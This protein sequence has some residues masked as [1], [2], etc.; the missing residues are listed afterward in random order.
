M[1]SILSGGSRVNNNTW[2][3]FQ[4]AYSTAL[5]GLPV[6]IVWGQARIT[7][8]CTWYGGFYYTQGS[9][10]GSG[11]GGKGGALSSGKYSNQYNYYASA[12]FSFCEG[13]IVN[14]VTLYYNSN[15]YSPWYNWYSEPDID[16]GQSTAGNITTGTPFYGNYGQDPWGYL[17]ASYPAQALSYRGNAFLAYENMSL[18]SSSSLP[19]I[20]CEILAPINSGVPALGPDANPFDVVIDFLTNANYGIPGFSSAWLGDW[21]QANLY[22]RA[23]GLM[24]SPA[25]TSQTTGTQFLQDLAMAINCEFFLSNGQLQCVPYADQSESGNGVVYS[26]NTTPI[27][28]LTTDDFL[29]NQGG[30]SSGADTP[31]TITRKNRALIPNHV[32]F[33]YLDRGQYYNPYTVDAWDEASIAQWRQRDDDKQTMHMFCLQSAAQQSA[34]LYLARKQI[35]TT[36]QFTV[37]PQFVLL[38]PMDVVTLTEPQ[39]GMYNVP[40]RITE[41]KENDDYTLTITADEYLGS[42]SAPL[43]GSQPPLAGVPNYNAPAPAPNSPVIFEPPYQ[44]AN[45]LEVWVAVSAQDAANYGGCNVW[46][47]TDNASYSLLGNISGNATMGTLTAALPAVAAALSGTTIDNTNTLAVDLTESDGGL[48]SVTATAMQSGNTACYV[49]G[50]IIAFQTATLTA[51]NKYNLAPL[52][53]GLYDSTIGA[54]AAGSNFVALGSN[55]NVAKYDYTTDKIG[56]AVYFKFQSYNIYEGGLLDLAALPVTTYTITGSPLAAA[57]AAPTNLRTVFASGFLQLWWDEITDF[58]SGILYKVF[59]GPQ[60]ASAMQVGPAQAHPPFTIMGPDTY[61]VVACVQPAVG[62]Y[63]Q[64]A[65]VSLAIGG[66]MLVTNVLQESNEQANNWPGSLENGAIVGSSPNEIIAVG[67]AVDYGLASVAVDVAT[68][69]GLASA[70][71]TETYD[72]GLASQP[73]TSNS[74]NETTSSD[75]VVELFIDA[76]N[77]AYTAIYTIAG[78]SIIDLGYVSTVDINVQWSAVGVPAGQNILSLADFLANPDIFGAGSTQYIEAYPEISIGG[79]GGNDIYSL[80]N[81]YAPA[82]IFSPQTSTFSAWQK[83]QPG[84]YQGQYFNLRMVVS[85]SN[86]QVTAY[87]TGFTYTVNRQARLD[88]YQNVSVPTTGLTISFTPDG[89]TSPVPFNGGPN[90]QADPFIQVTWN[91]QAGDVLSI[92]ALSQSSVTIEILNGGVGVARTGVNVTAEGY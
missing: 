61:W 34:S 69:W 77:G 31:I 64:S 40:V 25:L 78:E 24:V 75:P 14:F 72:L 60:F 52:A 10:K 66:N 55:D 1:A 33:E 48:T 39:T 85:C 2:P 21:T 74:G 46:A 53:R 50:E 70:A 9:G 88:H 79:A 47:S 45:G 42:V 43:Y 13:P 17:E 76:A 56:T 35:A 51:A 19:N 49:D 8:N 90:G 62:I 89:T 26:Q 12:I 3:S 82:D 81:V 20:S 29:P 32:T 22:A 38:D 87:L 44:E 80:P 54:H 86:P 4:V 37:G 11:G 58:R 18:G 15:A 68:D 36:F 5:A 84:T 67:G 28:D 73:T 23:L 63:V 30:S 57:I 83:F 59:K 27:Y 71:A 92:T 6:P 7:A 16:T 41:I 65:P 91:N